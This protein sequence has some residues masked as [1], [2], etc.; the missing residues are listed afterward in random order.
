M[1]IDQDLSELILYADYN[2]DNYYF[3]SGFSD[4]YYSG[5]E[6][7]IFLKRIYYDQV[8]SIIIP[9]GNLIQEFIDKTLPYNGINIKVD[10]NGYNFN[11][12]AFLKN[13]QNEN[14]VFNPK[15]RVVYLK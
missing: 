14:V 5:L 10:G 11:Y 2:N 4:I 1:L 13:G 3:N 9:I 7:D 12:P 15:L 6:N 8:D